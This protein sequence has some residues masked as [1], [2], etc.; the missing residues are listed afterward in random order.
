MNN[1]GQMPQ[2]FL[3]RAE[4]RAV[5]IIKGRDAGVGLDDI[6]Q[7]IMLTLLEKYNGGP[8]GVNTIAASISEEAD[9]IEEVYEPYLIQLGF[10]NRTPRG[11]MRIRMGSPGSAQVTRCRLLEQWTNLDVRTERSIL[12]LRLR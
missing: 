9:T 3:G 4:V 12:F 10:L 8:V 7:K 1:A 5:I 6:D 2:E 11:E